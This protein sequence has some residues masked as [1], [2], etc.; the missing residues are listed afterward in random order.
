MKDLHDK[1]YIIVDTYSLQVMGER[2]FY[3]LNE[4][5]QYAVRFSDYTTIKKHLTKLV[6]S[7]KDSYKIYKVEEQINY[8]FEIM[9]GD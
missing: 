5:K 4:F 9:S 7:D 2:G 1:Y 8:D 6:D 3:P